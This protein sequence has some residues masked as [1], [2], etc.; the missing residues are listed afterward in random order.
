MGEPAA[1]VSSL[2]VSIDT[3]PNPLTARTGAPRGQV[4]SPRGCRYLGRLA[5]RGDQ[6]DPHDPD[7]SPDATDR[8]GRPPQGEPDDRAPDAPYS[9]GP[10]PV[11][12]PGAPGGSWTPP[13]P[14][15]S[16]AR[17]AGGSGI[18][19]EVEDADGP[20]VPPPVRRRRRRRRAWLIGAVVAVVGVP[21]G[22]VVATSFGDQDAPPEM[23]R[24]APEDEAD[25]GGSDV[26][27]GDTDDAPSGDSDGGDADGEELGRLD[28]LD[29]E[30]LDGTDAVYGQLLVD[31]DASEQVMVGFQDELSTAS[32]MPFESL[33]AR[34]TALQEIAVASRDD[35]LVVR[36]RLDDVLEVDG[37]EEV[38]ERYL[39][40]LESW[41]DFMGAV[42]EDPGVLG[43]EGAG[44][45]FTVVINATGDAFARALEDEL[46]E[47]ADA[48][49]R[50]YADDLLDR[51]FRGSVDAQV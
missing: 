27:S 3:L 7:G 28:P 19:I 14:A 4:R 18:D 9:P 22:F 34:V 24:D 2:G 37:A 51:G 11:A 32:S 30:A 15:T 20:P 17:P 38:R 44:A 29:L 49:V 41:A 33:D 47:T 45:G 16:V 21:L 35:L 5:K 6:V 1:T 39:A 40:H 25:E 50:A 10:P 8:P 31:I 23:A 46:P 42:A 43:G 12:P 36:D 13:E 48:S 26:P